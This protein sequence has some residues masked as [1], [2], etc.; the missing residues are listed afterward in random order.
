[1]L[2]QHGI[3]NTTS[4][5]YNFTGYREGFKNSCIPIPTFHIVK[6]FKNIFIP[7]FIRNNKKKLP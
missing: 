1:M 4:T 7:A 5:F 2:T 6:K 3:L